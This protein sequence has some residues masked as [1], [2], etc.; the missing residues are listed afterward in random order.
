MAVLSDHVLRDGLRRKGIRIANDLANRQAAQVAEAKKNGKFGYFSKGELVVE[1]R[2]PSRTKAAHRQKQNQTAT[3]VIPGNDISDNHNHDDYPELQRPD[4][5]YLRDP[6]PF[7]DATECD[8]DAATGRDSIGSVD[9][10]RCHLDNRSRPT[11][12]KHA[13]NEE[14]ADR[15][16][17]RADRA[18]TSDNSTNVGRRRGR[19][20]PLPPPHQTVWPRPMD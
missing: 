1:D 15:S 5:R 19:G 17:P 13:V 18:T 10:R 7:N 14:R 12:G 11:L 8:S 20:T 4:H 2:R 16:R 3:A 9:Q 6:S